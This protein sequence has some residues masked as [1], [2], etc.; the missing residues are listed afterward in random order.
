MTTQPNQFERAIRNVVREMT[1]KQLTKLV[2]NI[3]TIDPRRLTYCLIED[4]IADYKSVEK[5]HTLDTV[6]LEFGITSRQ[7]YYNW[8]EKYHRDYQAM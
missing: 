2:P 7:T 3:P 1:N 5:E 6:L 8:Y 4:R